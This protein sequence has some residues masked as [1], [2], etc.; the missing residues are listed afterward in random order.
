MGNED[1]AKYIRIARERIHATKSSARVPA[2][3]SISRDNNEV[4]RIRARSVYN[5]ERVESGQRNVG[6]ILVAT[7][8][9]TQERMEWRAKLRVRL[10]PHGMMLQLLSPRRASKLLCLIEQTTNSGSSGR[11][12]MQRSGFPADAPHSSGWPHRAINKEGDASMSCCWPLS[13]SLVHFVA[14]IERLIV[15]GSGWSLRTHVTLAL[16]EATGEILLRERIDTTPAR[17][18]P[19]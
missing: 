9:L 16:I 18:R 13:R 8:T 6:S 3:P 10:C 4:V 12:H 1:A 11:R 14:I 17:R 2:T 5:I 15:A 19:G 7:P